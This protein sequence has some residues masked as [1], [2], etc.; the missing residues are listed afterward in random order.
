MNNRK[1]NTALGFFSKSLKALLG[2]ALLSACAFTLNGCTDFDNGYTEKEILYN[3]QFGNEFGDVDPN[4]NFNTAGIAKLNV[5]INFSGEYTVKV[6][7]ANPRY[8]SSKCYLLGQFDKVQSG[9]HTFNCDVPQ[10]LEYIYI[11]IIDKDEN[12]MILPAV[13]KDGKAEV[14][15][16]QKGTRSVLT[17]LTGNESAK[18]AAGSFNN[19]SSEFTYSTVAAK[20]W[21]LTDLQAPIETLPESKLNAGKV[22]QNFEFSSLG[23]FIIYP[24]YSVTSNKGR[25]SEFGE[26]GEYL[27]IYTYNKYGALVA[28]DDGTPKIT[29]IWHMN[30]GEVED[31]VVTK[32][33]WFQAHRTA[34]NS[35]QNMYWFEN[36]INDGI[37]SD[38]NTVWSNN[39]FRSEYDKIRSEG[40]LL[41]I[42]SG[43][44]FGFVL[45]TDPS[46]Y[47]SNSSFNQDQ[48]SA[49]NDFG[50]DERDHIKDT[51][52]ATFH[53]NGSMYMAFEDW[54]YGGPGGW[55]GPDEG[56]GPDHDFNDIV[57]KLEQVNNSYLPLII[58]KD[59]EVPTMIY[60]VACE[61]LGGTEDWD[62]NDIVFGIKHVSG[63][64]KA[65]VC[66][67]AAG[68]VL[69]AEIY[70]NE[71]KV[72]FGASNKTEVHDV[73]DVDLEN[74]EKA[75][76]KMVNTG[77]GVTRNA[78]DS[79]P[80][81]V[82]AQ[83][84]SVFTD[85][86]QFRISVKYEGDA[87][88]SKASIG[89]P[90]RKGEAAAQAFLIADPEWE[91]PTERQKISFK[92]PEFNT[93]VK[94]LQNAKNWTNTVWGNSNEYYS[95]P[96]EA[97]NLD[98]Y[99]GVS[100]S[101]NIATIELR[102]DQM[103]Y[104]HTYKLVLL[105]SSEAGIRFSLGNGTQ[106]S[107]MPDG[108]IQKDMVTTF[109]LDAAV[110][111]AIKDSGTN[112][113]VKITFAS[114]KTAKDELRMV[115]WY[116][117]GVKKDCK[118]EIANT[119]ITLGIPMGGDHPTA[120]I[121]YTTENTDPER[122]VY[123]SSSNESV[124]TVSGDGVLTA[125][126][127][128]TAIITVRLD[129]TEH[130]N[131][132]TREVTV[133]VSKRDPKLSVDQV[134]VS[135]NLYGGSK[136]ITANSN[137]TNTQLTVSSSNTGVATVSASN[138]YI[139][140]TPTGVGS[141][142]IKV[143]QAANDDYV[144]SEEIT[145][146]V[147]VNLGVEMVINEDAYPVVV[148]EN[149]TENWSTFDAVDV[150]I[151]AN[152]NI[153]NG[154]RFVFD[155]GSNTGVMTF[156]A[157]SKATEGKLWTFKNGDWTT[158]GTW[159]GD[160][161]AT[162]HLVF[163]LSKAEFEQYFQGAEWRSHFFFGGNSPVPEKVYVSAK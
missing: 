114:G 129:A 23:Q 18:V 156:Y 104:N 47:F 32:S 58:D 145:I 161:W 127:A 49:K 69:P 54:N 35:W 77:V 13:L 142:T 162:R 65:T 106:I 71:D 51:Y 78:V 120:Q 76:D 79:N 14:E 5:T 46:N 3:Q 110:V 101:G 40:I 144:E 117:D 140:I 39:S 152:W 43:I 119:D 126:G 8:E 138:Q 163:E 130:F 84:F 21:S 136:T 103:A 41:N 149:V 139:T 86:N 38:N 105:G 25:E 132:A 26:W 67:L 115:Y 45:A 150:V 20:A 99:G 1:M 57:F 160:N 158:T 141:T 24:I 59:T 22:T 97:M 135:A 36:N 94:D 81:T 42:P 68:G 143:K 7:T 37:C 34:D 121:I 89:V 131:G 91:W 66:L 98:A 63:Q 75:A 96:S 88:Y 27:G 83:A 102:H 128:G 16:G 133:N 147:T 64:T 100:Y 19:T 55:T 10:T 90:D 148:D 53:S 50:F 82:S 60:I 124:V 11:G 153:D 62:F 6:Y 157:R 33:A 12:R 15:F 111:K 30:R 116:E 73:F 56:W 112:G 4:H 122:N 137:N 80:L 93:W 108:K 146:T 109:T 29:W 125:Q 9:E 151:A 44:R 95:L 113:S 72:T 74:A 134:S 92:Y 155:F 107:A 61:D 2:G 28:N 52:A 123:F 31:G 70:F 17:T 118:L 48:G 159:Y 85:A 154:V 87:D